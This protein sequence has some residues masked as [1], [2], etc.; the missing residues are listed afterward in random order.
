ME[1]GNHGAF[2]DRRFIE[3]GI[4]K[5][6]NIENDCHDGVAGKIKEGCDFAETGDIFAGEFDGWRLVEFLIEI[7]DD[8]VGIFG[9]I[10]GK[11]RGNFV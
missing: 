10:E 11:C 3:A 8:F 2:F 1:A 6:S 5:T 7:R 9:W 4:N